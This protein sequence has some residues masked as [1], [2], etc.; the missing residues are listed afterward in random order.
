MRN[1]GVH[2]QGLTP[3]LFSDLRSHRRGS[4]QQ[5]LEDTP[6]V[7]SLAGAPRLLT[8]GPRAHPLDSRCS[9]VPWA[10]RECGPDL[11][12]SLHRAPPVSPPGK[13][14]EPLSGRELCEDPTLR[15]AL[16]KLIVSRDPH[17][18]EESARS[19]RAGRWQVCSSPGPRVQDSARGDAAARVAPDRGPAPTQGAELRA[20]DPGQGRQ[21]AARRRCGGSC[22]RCRAASAA[23]A[24]RSGD[25]ALKRKSRPARPG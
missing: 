9:P 2:T 21:A 14:A 20:R 17:D 24:G 1:R 4:D 19:R 8:K 5:P 3:G 16:A 25:P 13:Q 7:H 10:H 12:W 22:V 6:P 23:P 15:R 18:T 11:P